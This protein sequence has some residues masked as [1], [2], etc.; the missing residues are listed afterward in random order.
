MSER[1]RPA[2]TFTA[3][4]TA[5]RVRLHYPGTDALA[6]SAKA[7]VAPEQVG[8]RRAPPP[9]AR[10]ERPRAAPLRQVPLLYGG[11]ASRPAPSDPERGRHSAP[12]GGTSRR[13]GPPRAG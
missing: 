7:G 1:G 10:P 13:T 2:S 3:S 5:T 12:R 6:T 4:L 11:S 9:R 8:A